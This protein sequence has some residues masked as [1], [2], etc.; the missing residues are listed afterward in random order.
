MEN[1][2]DIGL[3]GIFMAFFTLVELL[4]FLESNKS[5]AFSAESSSSPLSSLTTSVFGGG[6]P[7]DWFLANTD[8][9]SSQKL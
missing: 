2:K 9:D 1:N 5:E 8:A 6:T 7:I 3:Q 4:G